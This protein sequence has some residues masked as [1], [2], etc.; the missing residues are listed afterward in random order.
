MECRDVSALVQVER[1]NWVRVVGGSNCNW[2]D[3]GQPAHTGPLLNIAEHRCPH[4]GDAAFNLR[5][6]PYVH[7]TASGRGL[8]LVPLRRAQEDPP[9]PQRH[10]HL[11]TSLLE[12]RGHRGHGA[13]L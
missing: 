10:Q 1:G 9:V 8:P 3:R 2:S 12:Q 11:M 6:R 13:Q 7:G 5:G 4:Q